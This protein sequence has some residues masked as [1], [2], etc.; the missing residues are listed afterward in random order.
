MSAHEETELTV[1][2]EY[3]GAYCDV[4]VIVEWDHGDDEPCIHSVRLWKASDRY[5]HGNISAQDLEQIAH[6]ALV[7]KLTRDGEQNQLAEVAY[8]R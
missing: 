3:R 2:L 5:M 7:E 4:P 8:E 1:S 6:E